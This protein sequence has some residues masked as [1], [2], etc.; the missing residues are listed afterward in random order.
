MF[1]YKPK[2]YPVADSM[3]VTLMPE[4]LQLDETVVTANAIKREKRSL[5][6]ST[7]QVNNEDLTKGQSTTF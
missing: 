4:A 3:V 6:Y 1:G 5:G 7:Q 2:D